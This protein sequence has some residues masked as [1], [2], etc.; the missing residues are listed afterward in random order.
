MGC[1]HFSYTYSLQRS[2]S[3]KWLKHLRYRSSLLWNSLVRSILFHKGPQASSLS[4]WDKRPKADAKM[5]QASR[6]MRPL[7]G[8]W[9]KPTRTLV[10]WRQGFRHPTRNECMGWY[11]QILWG[12]TEPLGRVI[13]SSKEY[14]RPRPHQGLPTKPPSQRSSPPHQPKTNPQAIKKQSKV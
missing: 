5:R 11:A 12:E 1:K 8:G 7:W 9:G 4:N 14:K 10:S 2:V 13:L 3:G 6:T